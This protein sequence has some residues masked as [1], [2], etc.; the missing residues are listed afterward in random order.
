MIMKLR[1]DTSGRWFKGNTHIHSTASDG[2][3]TFAE[4]AGMYAGAGY[5]FL[6]RTD[7]WVASDTSKD[8]ES[9]PLLW[10]D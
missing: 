3:K 5:D 10:I 7:H 9:Y 8:A 4:L 1:Y 6:F 2:G